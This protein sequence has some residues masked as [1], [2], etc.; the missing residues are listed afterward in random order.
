ML[1]KLLSFFFKTPPE[2]RLYDASF[3]IADDFL[4]NGPLPISSLCD[5][6]KSFGAGMQ[7]TCTKV[8]RGHS[9]DVTALAVLKDRK[10]ASGSADKTVRIWEDGEC[11]LTLKGHTKGVT[12]LA[13]LLNGNLASGSLDATVCFWDTTQ[14]CC[15]SVMNVHR[16][17]VYA[18]AALPDGRLLSGGMDTFR[19]ISNIDIKHVS[20]CCG[21]G[22]NTFAIAVSPQGDIATSLGHTIKV[23]G[24]RPCVLFSGHYD[25]VKAL[26]M[27]SDGSIASAS[28]NKIIL[29]CKYGTQIQLCRGH[30]GAVH[31]LC[32]FKGKL[33]SGTQ[34]ATVSLWDDDGSR[35][36]A[37]TGHA[38]DVTAV[39]VLADG[40]L[41]SGSKDRTIRLWK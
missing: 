6:V 21:V 16:S 38:K 9:D 32:V 28:L 26:T 17:P 29:A 3:N 22:K 33:V 40:T 30:F 20:V 7:G 34:D 1:S 35:L 25:S 23:W 11:V 2:P 27:L 19:C 8:L 4:I 14:G 39:A 41:A 24:K 18:V 36:L 5:I 13:V 10:L 31:A 12:S 37:M 15:L